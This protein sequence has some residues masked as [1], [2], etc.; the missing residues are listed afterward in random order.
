LSA[1]QD[2]Q[3]LYG[4][5]A[6][7]TPYAKPIVLAEISNA[8]APGSSIIFPMIVDSGAD[9][10]C[11]PREVADQ[12]GH[13]FEAGNEVPLIGVSG[14]AKARRHGMKIR[15]VGPGV[16]AA[17]VNDKDI[18]PCTWTIEVTVCEPLRN[19]GLFGCHDFLKDWDF[20]LKMSQSVFYLIPITPAVRKSVKSWKK[21]S[22]R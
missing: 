13:N 22:Q 15:I 11:M 12:I 3:L 2:L 16:S 6:V 7:G 18:I 20:R 1:E 10:T 14:Q 17:S 9:F 8:H 5:S 19:V 4:L 21:L